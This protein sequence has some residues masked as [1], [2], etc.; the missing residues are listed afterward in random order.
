LE[1][2]ENGVPVD[3]LAARHA[4]RRF[5]LVLGRICPEKGIHLAIEAAKRADMPLLIAGE[6]FPYDAH[7]RYFTEEIAPRLDGER[8][9]IGPVGFVRKRRLLT[10]AR[11]LLVPSLAEE[12]SSLVA[13]E[14]AACGTPVIAFP[15]GAL[16]ETV[17]HGRTGWLVPDASAM[18][19]A[20]EAAGAIDPNLCRSVARERFSL[21]SMV[22]AYMDV[23]ERLAARRQPR[24]G[25][26]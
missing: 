21:E 25:A 8:R 19:A 17:E 12:T 23:Y 6:V 22:A 13:R 15:N 4:K 9:F 2:I 20:I 24:E 11:C 10:A 5:A 26:A 14:A 3:A 1:P 7:R 18:A 16:G